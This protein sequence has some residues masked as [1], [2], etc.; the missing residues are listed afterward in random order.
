MC[1]CVCVCMCVCVVV[2]VVL[3]RRR[4]KRRKNKTN[5]NSEFTLIFTVTKQTCKRTLI[6]TGCMK[7][8]A[9]TGESGA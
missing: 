7:P 4:K 1:V 8:E 3:R 6:D 9:G 5:C 2:V